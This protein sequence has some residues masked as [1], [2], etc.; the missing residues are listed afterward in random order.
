MIELSGAIK[1]PGLGEPWVA[2]L[3]AGKMAVWMAIGAMFCAAGASLSQAE[4]GDWL[5]SSNHPQR[6][7]KGNQAPLPAS[8]D[9]KPCSGPACKRS[10]VVPPAAPIRDADLL[11]K[12]ALTAGQ[13]LAGGQ[14]PAVGFDH[15]H[16]DHRPSDDFYPAL[17]R[18]PRE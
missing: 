15:P 10:P 3:T 11:S 5:S 13:L 9:E 12:P 14:A 2:R 1:L 17:R 4:C 16:D 8:T 18:P 6:M 7:E